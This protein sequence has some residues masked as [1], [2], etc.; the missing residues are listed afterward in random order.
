MKVLVDTC[1]WSEVLRRKKPA[2]QFSRKLTDLIKDGRVVIIGPIRQ[3]LLSG[4]SDSIQYKK[5]KEYFGAFD[6]IPLPTEVFEQAAEFCNTCR[7]KGIQ[8]S[9][10]D[11]L[12]CAVAYQEDLAIF[13]TD[14]DFKNFQKYL[15]IKLLKI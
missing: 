15:P 9:T 11:F 7:K 1:I 10:I 8:G 4:I 6:D 3:E 2:Y 14:C 5:L 13:S 12:I